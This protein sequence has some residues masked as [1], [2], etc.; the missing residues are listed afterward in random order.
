MTKKLLLFPIVLCFILLQSFNK[1]ISPIDDVIQ[2]IN[3]SNISL[4]SSYFDNTVE[5]ALPDKND[6]YSKSQAEYIL[7]D[8]FANNNIKSF[9]TTHKGNNNGSEYCIGVL[10]TQKG[11]YRL[12]FFV[13]Q[14]EGKILILEI[15]I[16]NQR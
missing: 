4:L 6:T 14:K 15:R 8:F 16:E 11:S 2:A 10:H 13:K 9:T 1:K 5:I 3:K 12:T 7:K